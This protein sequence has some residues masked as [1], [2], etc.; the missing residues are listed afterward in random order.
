MSLKII[1]AG[2]GRTG[3]NSLKL[4]LEKLLGKP[5]YHMFEAI[6]HPEHMPVWTEAA[7]GNPPDWHS[8][9]GAYGATVDGPAAMFWR[10]LMEAYP[11]AVVLLSVRD[12]EGW[13]RSISQTIRPLLS[14]TEPGPFQDMIKA[15]STRDFPYMLEESAAK[16]SFEAHN[17]RV[18]SEVPAQRLVVWKPGDGWEPICEAFNLPVPD[19]PFPHANSADD[20]IEKL[21]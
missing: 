8:F 9:L 13:W 16:A 18:K 7:R 3:T 10:E 12:T 21:M 15:H 20:F 2:Q 17:E 5:C 1:G 4:A 14:S 11:N 6:D 19:E